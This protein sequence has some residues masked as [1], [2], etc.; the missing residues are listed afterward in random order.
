M[1]S[2]GWD[3]PALPA[4]TEWWSSGLRYALSAG[5]SRLF[6]QHTR[7]VSTA[8]IFQ[9]CLRLSPSPSQRS[10]IKT[11]FSENLRTPSLEASHKCL[12]FPLFS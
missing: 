12:L 4:P 5:H 6:L 3:Q 1:A 8:Y 10:L 11:Y 7:C 9:L 2:V